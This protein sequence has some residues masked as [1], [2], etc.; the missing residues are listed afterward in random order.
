MRDSVG[1]A[2]PP[3]VETVRGHTIIGSP[4]NPGHGLSNG[5]AD[6]EGPEATKR[7]STWKK[8]AFDPFSDL[9]PADVRVKLHSA[10]MPEST[11][12]LWTDFPDG[13]VPTNAGA[14]L[15]NRP[16]DHG[17]DTDLLASV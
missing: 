8:A 4:L 13:K 12:Q 16:A 5:E 6:G 7:G 15:G 11:A 17:R 1:S 14:T 3:R 9:W 10:D 2:R